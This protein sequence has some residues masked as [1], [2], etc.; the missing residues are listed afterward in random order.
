MDFGKRLR[1]V[2]FTE[3]APGQRIQRNSFHRYRDIAHRA[4]GLG[5]YGF[6]GRIDDPPGAGGLSPN[7][8]V[9]FPIAVVISGNRKIAAKLSLHSPLSNYA[10]RQFC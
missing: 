5:P 7:C 6:V 3:R 1:L 9:G 4:Q 8:N 10:N 2:T